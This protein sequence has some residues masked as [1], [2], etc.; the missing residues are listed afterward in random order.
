[1]DT[2][3]A[4]AFGML[5]TTAIFMLIGIVVGLVKVTR[6]AKEIRDTK[7]EL[8]NVANTINRRIDESLGYLHHTIDDSNKEINHRIDRWHEEFDKGVGEL[9][10][11]IDSR[12][13][14]TEHKANHRLDLIYN[15]IEYVE[16]ILKANGITTTM[17]KPLTDKDVETFTKKQ[18]LKD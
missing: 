8:E 18:I 16:E 12:F 14:K 10:S 13:D 1:M 2:Q 4:F 9:Q 5:A 15:R 7:Q 17:V 6:Q 11:Q 3:L